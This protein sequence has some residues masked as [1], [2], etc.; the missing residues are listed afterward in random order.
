MVSAHES[1]ADS[2]VKHKPYAHHR[3]VS[4]TTT[5]KDLWRIGERM[6]KNEK[7]HEMNGMRNAIEW[8]VE[9]GAHCLYEMCIG[10]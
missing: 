9:L 1:N 4:Q 2:G 3:F 10:A 8:N 6:G 7:V 5:K